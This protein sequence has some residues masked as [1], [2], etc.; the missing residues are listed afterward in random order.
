MGLTGHVRCPAW[1]V[2]QVVALEKF[3]GALA[4]IHRIV[5]CAPDISGVLGAQRLLAHS[6]GRSR[7]QRQPH[8]HNNGREGLRTCPA[9][10]QTIWCPT[11]KEDCQSDDLVV[12]ADQVFGVPPDCSVH[13]RIKTMNLVHVFLLLSSGY[14]SFDCLMVAMGLIRSGPKGLNIVVDFRNSTWLGF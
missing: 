3:S 5:W 9:C 10:H 7:N 14:A 6:N 12:V 1:S 8:Q 13:P 4:K 2:G 11:E